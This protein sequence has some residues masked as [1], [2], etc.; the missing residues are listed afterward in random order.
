[1]RPAETGL[2]SKN[3]ILM[4]QLHEAEVVGLSK[5]DLVTPEEMRSVRAFVQAQASEARLLE[6]SVA[7]QVNLGQHLDIVHSDVETRKEAPEV[8]QRIFAGEK[9]ALGW[10]SSDCRISTNG[11]RLDIYDLIT[12]IMR[13]ISEKFLPENIAHV[14]VLVVSPLVNI[15]IS[16]VQDSMQVDGVKGGRYMVG[17]GELVLNVR[18]MSMP[19]RL[20]NGIEAVLQENFQR[21]KV[22]VLKAGTGLLVPRPDSPQHPLI[23]L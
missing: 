18:V 13:G 2:V 7:D 5:Q 11:G 3:M 8:D 20:R 12:S 19:E 6:L 16:L 15:K 1:M 14:K 4:Q 23:R 22:E 21:T 17:D 10:Y 9:A